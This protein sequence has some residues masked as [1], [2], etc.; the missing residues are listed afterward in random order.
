MEPNLGSVGTGAFLGFAVPPSHVA[1]GD[2]VLKDIRRRAGASDLRPMNPRTWACEMVS[3][4]DI[5]YPPTRTFLMEIGKVIPQKFGFGL[6]IEQV[7]GE[8]NATQ[9]RSVHLGFGGGVNLLMAL[10]EQMNEI[11]GPILRSDTHKAFLPGFEVAR[12]KALN[13]RSRTELGRALRAVKVPPNEPFI[14]GGLQVLVPAADA[15]GPYL[16]VVQEYGF[17]Q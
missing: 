8:P 1:I 9:P 12:L 5:G 15:N 2:M 6:N 13:D 11:A 3:L 4:P 17:S 16:Q 14:L 7:V 10:A